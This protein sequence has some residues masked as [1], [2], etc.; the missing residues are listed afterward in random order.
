SA[1][2]LGEGDL[3]VLHL[4]GL[5]C[6]KSA[7]LQCAALAAQHAE[8]FHGHVTDADFHNGAADGGSDVVALL[9]LV[10]GLDPHGPQPVENGLDPGAVLNDDG[11]ACGIAQIPG[12]QNAAVGGA[13]KGVAPAGGDHNVI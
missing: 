4:V 11:V 5:D 6:G 13:D 2:R 3:P 12:Q 8:G 9:D 1:P 7:H 10:P